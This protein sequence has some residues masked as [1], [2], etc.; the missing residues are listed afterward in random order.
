MTSAQSCFGWSSVNTEEEIKR[1]K[2]GKNGQ[3]VKPIQR[4]HLTPAQM[5]V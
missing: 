5:M 3:M 4:R 2:N 1:V